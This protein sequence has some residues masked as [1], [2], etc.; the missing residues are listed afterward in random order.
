[1]SEQQRLPHVPEKKRITKKQVRLIFLLLIASLAVILVVQNTDE[2]PITLWF[3]E[4]TSPLIVLM[5]ISM[6]L[7]ALIAII[8]ASVRA[9]RKKNESAKLRNEVKSLQD[10]LRKTNQRLNQKS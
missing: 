5:L 4:V 1:M 10:E 2:V 9:S 6:A 3:W 7:G 8:V